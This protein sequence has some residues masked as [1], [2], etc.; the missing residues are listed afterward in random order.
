MAR[1]KTALTPK[2]ISGLT[3]AI[4]ETVQAP[5][6]ILDS[7]LKVITASRSFYENFLATPEETE[8]KSIYDLGDHRWNIPELRDLLEKVLSEDKA[9]PDLEIELELPNVGR[10]V[11]VLNASKINL[12]EQFDKALLNAPEHFARL[13]ILALED[14]TERKKI[15]DAQLFLVQSGWVASGEDFFKSLARYLALNLGMDY[16]CIDRLQGEG[17]SAETVAIYFDGKF[18]DNVSYALKDTPCGDVV[19]KTICTFSE[20]VRHL[21]PRDLVLQDMLA[22]SYVGTTLWSSEGQPIGL[23]AIIGR[24]P[25]V[26]PQLAEWMLKMVSVRAAGELERRQAEEALQASSDRYRSYIEVTGALGWT[27]NADGEV[28]EDL[29]SW[30]KYTGQT[31]EEIRGQG[32]SKALHPGA[33]EHALHIWEKAVEGKSSYE[34]EYRIRRHDGIY[35]D[36][37]VRGIPV[38]NEYGGIREW[39]GTC[40]DITERKEAEGTLKALNQELQSTASELEVAY[41]DMESFSYSVSHDLR[42]PLRIIDGMSDILLQDY[43]DKLDDEGKNLLKLI[44]RNTKRMDELVLALLEL[45]KAGRQE[46]TIDEIDMK[47]ASGRIVADLNAMFPERSIK[48]DVKELPPAHGD[49]TLIQQVLANLLSNAVKFTKDRDVADIEVGGR[50]ED[51]KNVYYVKDNGV[52]FDTEYADKLFK[53][54]QRLHSLKEFEGI[55]I[56]LSIVQRIIQRHGGRV[57]AEGKPGEGATFY[58]TLPVKGG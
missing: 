9:S 10:R 4:V 36:F 53:V 22:E 48:V 1:K 38:L 47:K 18:E 44:Q 55:G 6:L 31:F 19:G 57:W 56:G 33:L 35:R 27:T 8:N 54:F 16:V 49:L 7:G 58:F 21:F 11:M 24:K 13:V 45:G 14:V 25:L 12:K 46:M 26:N 50:R 42:A 39:V 2:S 23:I 32:W 40:I 30:R 37:M 29:P 3:N 20:G 5:L 43:H 15:E 41:K 28:V 51:S 34:V 17:L 52:G